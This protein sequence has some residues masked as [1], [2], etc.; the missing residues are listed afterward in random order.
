MIPGI[1]IALS[2]LAIGM[3]RKQVSAAICGVVGIEIKVS[4]YHLKLINL[5]IFSNMVYVIT[6]LASIHRQNMV[7][8]REL[9]NHDHME[10]FAKAEHQKQ[11]FVTYRNLLMNICS[12]VLVLCLNVATEQY[13]YYQDTKK[14][15]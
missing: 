9:E 10:H 11:L 2:I 15:A 1:I 14:A 13:E 12:I 4:G 7:Q 5:M 8:A 6:S 3:G